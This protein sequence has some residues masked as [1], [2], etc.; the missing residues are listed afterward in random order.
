MSTGVSAVT[1][2]SVPLDSPTQT[3]TPVLTTPPVRSAGQYYVSAQI[4]LVVATGDT[5]ACLVSDPTAGETGAF[6]TVG[7]VPNQTYETLP[8]TVDIRASA[9]DPISVLCTGYNANPITS[10]Y[11]G[12]MTATLINSDNPPAAGNMA[13]RALQSGQ[14]RPTRPPAVSPR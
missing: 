8:L 10:L 2:T 9:G 11:D 4:M 13:V 12:A 3:L 1:Q 6:S 14:A 5:V 7:P